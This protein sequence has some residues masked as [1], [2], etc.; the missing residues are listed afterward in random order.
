MH[1]INPASGT[2]DSITITGLSA[3]PFPTHTFTATSVYNVCVSFQEPGS[4]V[5]T[6][7][8]R[9][10]FGICCD[11][12]FNNTDSCL[13]NSCLFSINTSA[14]INRINWNFGDIANGINNTSNAFNPSHQFTSFGN[15]TVMATIEATCGTFT[16]TANVSIINSNSSPCTGSTS[17]IDSCASRQTRFQLNSIYPVISVEWNFN[18]P[19]SETLNTSTSIN[20][21]HQFKNSGTY[22]VRVIVNF[23]CRTD[24]LYKIIEIIN[25]DI[26]DIST[27]SIITPNAFHPIMTT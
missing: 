20:P 18:D 7:C 4:S 23:K 10:S 21:N 15:Y 22:N 14:S 19:S 26:I 16:D 8:R 13:Q 27:C 11:G 12:V 24:T 1:F 2:N 3:S 6:V 25:C 5:S 17:I 9:I